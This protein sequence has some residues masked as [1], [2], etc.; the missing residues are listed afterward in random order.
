VFSGREFTTFSEEPTLSIF[1][2]EEKHARDT[3]I[4]LTPP[5]LPKILLFLPYDGHRRFFQKSAKLATRLRGVTR[6][7]TFTATV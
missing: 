2:A 6:H 3:V 7:K 5:F 1:Q 4:Y